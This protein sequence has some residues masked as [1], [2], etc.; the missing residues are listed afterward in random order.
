MGA[1]LLTH[2]RHYRK[3]T[4]RQAPIGATPCTH[5]PILSGKL[6]LQI[7][8]WQYSQP[9]PPDLCL[10]CLPKNPEHSRSR[11]FDGLA[12]RDPAMH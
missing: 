1:D 12:A 6:P 7:P 9:H 4:L 10:C 3:T 5:V 2:P 11:I 8:S